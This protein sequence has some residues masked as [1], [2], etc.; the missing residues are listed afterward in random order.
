MLA[1]SAVKMTKNAIKT[2]KSSIKNTKRA[3]ARLSDREKL[4]SIANLLLG[5]L[6]ISIRRRTPI[7]IEKK[8]DPTTEIKSGT[9][10]KDEFLFGKNTSCVETLTGLTNL[11]LKLEQKETPDATIQ[12]GFADSQELTMNDADVA[13]VDGFVQRMRGTENEN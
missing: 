8:D 5:R 6:E 2:P 10:K 12:A 11:L 3:K 13:L 7:K 4:Q 1:K 9:E